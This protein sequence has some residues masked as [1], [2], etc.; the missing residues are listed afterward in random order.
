MNNLQV[1]CPVCGSVYEIGSEETEKIQE[2]AISCFVCNQ[3]MFVY[4]G[5]TAYYPF[6]KERKENHIKFDVGL[7]LENSS[8]SGEEA[9][10]D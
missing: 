1:E 3:T 7:P 8:L 6:L 2:G 9:T 10:T 5:L 4:D